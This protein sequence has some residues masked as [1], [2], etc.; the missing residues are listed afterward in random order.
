MTKFHDEFFKQK[1]KEHDQLVGVTLEHIDEV[2]EL[3]FPV[4]TP[5][6]HIHEWFYCPLVGAGYSANKE[7][8]AYYCSKYNDGCEHWDEKYGPLKCKLVKRPIINKY[9]EL[10]FDGNVFYCSGEKNRAGEDGALQILKDKATGVE[11]GAVCSCKELETVTRADGQQLQHEKKRNCACVLDDATRIFTT[12]YPFEHKRSINKETEHIFYGYNRFILGFADVILEV[13]DYFTAYKGDSKLSN[14]EAWALFVIDCK[15]KLDDM[16]AV[17][18]Q[19]KTYA[20]Q[21]ARE[22]GNP[23]KVI[24]TCSQDIPKYAKVIAENEAIKLVIY[25]KE[26]GRFSLAAQQSSN[27]NNTQATLGA[28]G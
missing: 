21:L 3:I 4:K 2:A 24:I 11:V 7:K 18:R 12:E 23:D 22:R 1:G 28:P 8:E 20:D 13:G 10:R 19:I 17:A 15:P 9:G 5:E 14:K 25:D 16:G 27:N 6:P 26:T